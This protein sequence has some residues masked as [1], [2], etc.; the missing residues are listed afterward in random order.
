MRTLNIWSSPLF[1]CA[2][3]NWVSYQT[4]F[5]QCWVSNLMCMRHTFYKASNIQAPHFSCHSIFPQK[6][7][8]KDVLLWTFRWPDICYITRLIS[9][10]W[11]FIFL[12]LIKYWS[13]ED[14]PHPA[15]VAISSW[16]YLFLIA[17]S[18]KTS[19]ENMGFCMSYQISLP[20]N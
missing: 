16:V 13:C 1:Q 19:F 7:K 6:R 18:S 3:I 11:E 14:V 4:W 10:L 15:L 20:E 9:N 12:C 5:L 8:R 2:G 17:P